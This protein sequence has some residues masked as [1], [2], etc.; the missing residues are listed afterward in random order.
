M[1]HIQYIWFKLNTINTFDSVAFE[2]NRRISFTL[3]ACQSR[4][5]VNTNTSNTVVTD[6]LARALHSCRQWLG[7]TQVNCIQHLN[8]RIIQF[9]G[10]ELKHSKSLCSLREFMRLCG[11]HKLQIH[12]V[13]KWNPYDDFNNNGMIETTIGSNSI[14][15]IAVGVVFGGAWPDEMEE[16]K[17]GRLCG[18]LTQNLIICD[19]QKCMHQIAVMRRAQAMAH[20]KFIEL[21][22]NS[23]LFRCECIHHMFFIRFLGRIYACATFI[24]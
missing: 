18:W 4:A 9:A 3:P 8:Q 14:R 5:M 12:G 23:G 10:D 17:G 13:N 7:L 22:N 24:Y 6:I 21:G 2:T 19:N 20:W 1:P 11:A 16:R 15:F